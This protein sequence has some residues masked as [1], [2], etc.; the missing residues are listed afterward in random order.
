MAIFTR[1]SVF[2]WDKTHNRN[3][4]EHYMPKKL[5]I[6]AILMTSN[7]IWE[8]GYTKALNQKTIN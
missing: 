5:L 1:I 8:K 7:R 3:G 4:S 2:Y 6:I